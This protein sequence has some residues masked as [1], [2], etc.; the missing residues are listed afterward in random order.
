MSKIPSYPCPACQRPS[1]E[2]ETAPSYQRGKVIEHRLNVP[3][4]QNVRLE[5]QEAAKTVRRGALRMVQ[6]GDCGLVWNSAFD[7]KLIC[8][9]SG[10][11]N[12]VTSSS[13][14]QKHLCDMADRILASVPAE[15]DIH[16]VEIGCG[17][18]DFLRLLLERGKGRVASAVGFDPAFTAQDQLPENAVVHPCYF[19]PDEIG[20]IPPQ[21]NVVCSRHTIEHVSDVQGFAANLAAAMAPGRQ[22]FVETPDVDWIL[23]NGAFQDF[24][25][26][27]CTLYN[28]HSISLLL[29]QYGLQSEVTPVYDGQYMW[30][31]AQKADSNVPAISPPLS[32]VPWELGQAYRT[33]RTELLD[34]WSSFLASR[35]STGPIAIW[36]AASKGVTFSLLM[37]V[38]DHQMISVGIDL[39]QA[40]QGCY[41]PVTGTPIVSPETAKQLG[42]TTIVI[43]NPNYETEIRNMITEMGWAAEVVV[44]NENTNGFE[45]KRVS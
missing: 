5:T 11:N 20:K 27:H 34:V 42:V 30:I 31:R 39:N 6:C 32:V 37:N 23:R 14:Y 19:T 1:K 33:Q 28:P 4:L 25:Y 35:E 22:L 9:D 7:P 17:E 13:F 8:Y 16:Y 43:M 45:C 38:H 44:L 29:S 2:G 36:G 21:A 18:G 24:F 10:Y 26:E 40:K 12:D 41:M 15:V 3:T